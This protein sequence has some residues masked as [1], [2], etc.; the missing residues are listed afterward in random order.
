MKKISE[1]EPVKTLKDLGGDEKFF[2]LWQ[3]A[4]SLLSSNCRLRKEPTFI[5]DLATIVKTLQKKNLP[6]TKYY[7]CNN[8]LQ[9]NYLK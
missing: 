5:A 8:C 9:E 3:N 4:D 1:I 6:L 7:I 2:T